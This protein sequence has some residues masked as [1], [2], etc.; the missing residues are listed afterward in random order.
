MLAR[1]VRVKAANWRGDGTGTREREPCHCIELYSVRPVDLFGRPG[2][3]RLRF[4]T[5]MD[6]CFGSFTIAPG[7]QP[8]G[9]NPS[10]LDLPGSNLNIA[11]AF[12]VP[13]Q[14]NSVRP[15]LSNATALGCAPKRSPAFCRA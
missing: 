4:A 1:A 15:D 12:C 14:A 9:I 13:L 11:T 3:R 2:L 7:N 5:Q 6:L 8:T 10:N